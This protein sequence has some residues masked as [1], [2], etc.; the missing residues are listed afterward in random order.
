MR[1]RF[2]AHVLKLVDFVI[3]T[4]HPSCQ[5]DAEREGIAESVNLDWTR[6][7]VVDAPETEVDEGFVEFKAYMQEDGA[8]HC[9]HERSRFVREAGQWY[10][11]DGAFPEPANDNP[12][13]EKPQ[14]ATSS[15]VGRNDPCPCGS[16]KKYKKCC[17]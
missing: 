14:P 15:K 16:G 17:G 12:T 10:Y 9:M 3:Q 11:I 5:A 8:E 2:A 1:A 6:L 4:Y 7:E 13:A